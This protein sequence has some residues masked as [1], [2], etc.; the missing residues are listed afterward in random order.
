MVVDIRGMERNLPVVAPDL[1]AEAERFLGSRN[2]T[3]LRVEW[4]K[5]ALNV[6]LRRAGYF[7]NSSLRAADALALG[8]R[9]RSPAIGAIAVWSHHTGVIAGM[10]PRGPLLISGNFG[11][12]V[13]EGIQRR[14]RF[15]GYVEPVRR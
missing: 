6:W 2:F 7:A 11:H 10:T 1:V 8:P 13:A 12:R 9:L 3:G 14:G 4:C 5:A 15:L